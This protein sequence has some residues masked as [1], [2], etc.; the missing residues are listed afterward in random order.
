MAYFLTFLL[1]FLFFFLWLFLENAN[2]SAIHDETKPPV[3]NLF[4][5]FIHNYALMDNRHFHLI[6]L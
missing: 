6:L 5:G 4:R 3:H 2:Q 1:F